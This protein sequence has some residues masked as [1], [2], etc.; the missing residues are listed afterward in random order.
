M[1]W[2]EKRTALFLAIFTILAL[3][4]YQLK[5]S[6]ILG[7]PSQSFSFFQFLGP[8]G[9]GLFSVPLGV[10]SVIVVEILNFALGGQALDAI[11]VAR[12]FPMAFAAVYFGFKYSESKTGKV[13]SRLILLVPLACM[14]L[15][16]AHPE[17]RAAWF[18]SLYWLIP[19]IAAV[20]FESSLIARALGATFTAHAIGSIAFLYAFNIPTATWI[21]LIPIV[22]V[23]RGL[24]ALGIAA[25]IV[26]F[27][28]ALDAAEH[29][30]H[31][32]V[33]VHYDARYSLLSLVRA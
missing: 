22:A 24:F 9:S 15:F 23:E 31:W 18:Y 33:P 8:I 12:F 19:V 1:K 13:S 16:I 3:L 29:K 28:T 10:A 26:A 25:S 11:T 27:S 7:V 5:F 14:A 30:A 6:T 32:R 21:T 17:G 2:V 20:W 4:A